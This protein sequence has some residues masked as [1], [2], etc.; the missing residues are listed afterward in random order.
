MLIHY[1]INKSMRKILFNTFI[2]IFV[3]LNI[4]AQPRLWDLKSMDNAI[5]NPNAAVKHLINEADKVLE[6]KLST[7]V[8]K[9]K[10]A[11]T[12]DIHDYISCG[13]YW[14]P[15]PKNPTG[16]YIRKDGESNV[17]VLTADKKNLS[18]MTK[19]IITLSLTYF[20]TKN[21]KYAEKAV[22][23][24]DKWFLN[25][26]TR[27]NPNLNFGQ[28]IQGYY[29]GEG[30]GA[31]IIETYTFVEMLDGIEL[32]KKS[33]AYTQKINSGLN[34]W[35]SEYL[36]WMMT[37]KVGNQEQN[38]K[39]NHGTAFDAQAARIALFLNKDDIALKFINELS[40][41][42]IFTQIEPDGKQPLELARTKAFHY[43][44]FNLTHIL[45]MCFMAKTLNIDLMKSTSQD[46]RSIAKGFEFL[47]QFVGK[48]QNDFPYKQISS[49][50]E[51]QKKICWDLYRFDK[52][53]NTKKHLRLYSDYTEQNADNLETL[54][55]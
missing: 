28:T 52:L 15:D 23:N 21:E 3:S 53:N 45:D 20:I 4:L 34:N 17:D 40:E 8:E 50:D 42:R 24:L 12:K 1:S 32:L 16:P 31:G 26:E 37:S 6:K 44:T 10:L 27:M 38:A 43:S 49:W 35:F 5:K 30:R 29:D 55:Y 2:L 36:N 14:W 39:N 51:A 19:G 11:P 46:G 54:L 47:V 13:P 33:P 22:D 7:V 48:P 41:K 25:P 9:T 18:L